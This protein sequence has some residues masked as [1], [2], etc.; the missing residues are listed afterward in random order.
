LS[1]QNSFEGAGRLIHVMV[2][3]KDGKTR[4]RITESGG[5]HPVFLVAVL[6]GGAL[7]VGLFLAAMNDGAPFLRTAVVF[8]AAW[9][10]LF[11]GARG[12]FQG[13]IRR[14]VRI[15]SDLLDR[16]SNHVVATAPHSVVTVTG[17]DKEAGE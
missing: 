8:G 15:L 9:V 14:R 12:L 4:I 5:V 7:G 17:S 6:G 11:A 16:L 13:F 3:P 2:K 1:F 10:A